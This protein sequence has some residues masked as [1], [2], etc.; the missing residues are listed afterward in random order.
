VKKEDNNELI[1]VIAAALA[2]CDKRTGYRLVVKSFRRISQTS[3][4]WSTAGKLENNN[5]SY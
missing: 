2:A 4:V 3:P 5:H 1:G